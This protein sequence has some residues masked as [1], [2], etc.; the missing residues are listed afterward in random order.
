[1]PSTKLMQ[2]WSINMGNKL[3]N[4]PRSLAV[5]T[6]LRDGNRPIQ[7]WTSTP[8]RHLWS[9]A[10]ERKKKS[11]RRRHF[12]VSQ[13]HHLWTRMCCHHWTILTRENSQALTAHP[14]TRR[15]IPTTNCTTRLERT[16]KSSMSINMKVQSINN[17]SFICSYHIKQWSSTNIKTRRAG[18]PGTGCTY[19]T[20]KIFKNSYK[21]STNSKVK[22]IK[23]PTTKWQDH[24][25]GEIKKP[26]NN[27]EK[28]IPMVRLYQGL[29]RRKERRQTVS[30]WSLGGNFGLTGGF[31]LYK[32]IQSTV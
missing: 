31:R 16:W 7:F 26:F 15:E 11:W 22:A 10:E 9:A 6:L 8:L 12:T 24:T 21:T 2:Y 14:S 1:M 29:L 20:H 32:L 17:Q 27:A 19:K 5:E 13:L 3:N 28:C 23:W 25:K 4:R 18:Q 30:T